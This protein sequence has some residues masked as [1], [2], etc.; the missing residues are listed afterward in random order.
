MFH[1]E[2][3]AIAEHL[4][5][6]GFWS[7]SLT[8]RKIGNGALGHVEATWLCCLSTIDSCEVRPEIHHPNTGVPR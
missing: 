6:S 5:A 4:T 3:P 7:Q 2:N 8:P 1:I